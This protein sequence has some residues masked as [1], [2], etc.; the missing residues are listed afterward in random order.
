MSYIE[1]KLLAKEIAGKQRH[2]SSLLLLAVVTRY[3]SPYSGQR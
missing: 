2:S 1:F 3:L